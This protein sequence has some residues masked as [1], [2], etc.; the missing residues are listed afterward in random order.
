MRAAA[1]AGEIGGH[2]DITHDLAD[3]AMRV[4]EARRA[5]TKPADIL[6]Q[7]DAFDRPSPITEKLIEA[8]YSPGMKRPASVKAVTSFLQDY[9]DEAKAQKPTTTFSAK[10]ILAKRRTSS[11]RHRCST[12]WR[13]RTSAWAQ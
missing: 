1:K 2:Y 5:G 13:R 6:T 11:T 3:A 10:A 8:F 9:I 4:A 12:L 7:I